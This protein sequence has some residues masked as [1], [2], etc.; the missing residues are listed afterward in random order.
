MTH[1][2]VCG[3]TRENDVRRAVALGARACGFILTNASRRR[4]SAVQARELAAHAGD[5]L[6]VAVVT[7]ESADWI[8]E[9]LA[10]SGLAA[11]QLSAG[12]DGAGVAA[13]RAAAAARGLRPLVIAAADTPDAG[14]AEYVVFDA[15]SPQA[16]GGTGTTLNWHDLAR[17]DLPPRRQIILAGGLSP[18]NVAQAIATLQP[19]FVD[20]SSGIEAAPGR[21]DEGLMAAFFAAVAR[22][23]EQ[24]GTST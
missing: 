7:T 11:V 24:G 13:V 3:L 20:V 22:A 17:S 21:K 12:A 8:A 18:H 19:A 6:T 23:D 2:K 4:I 15:R 9:Q 16:Y 14:A 10:A 1:V 5:A